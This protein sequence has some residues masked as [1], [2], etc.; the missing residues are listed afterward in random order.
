MKK[1]FLLV[2]TIMILAA[3]SQDKT[4]KYEYTFTGQSQY[5]TGDLIVKGSETFGKKA[6]KTTY[7]NNENTEFVLKYKGPI[8]EMEQVKTIKYSYKTNTGEGSGT[9]NISKI[10]PNDEI[11]I[12][13]KTASKG[14]AKIVKDEVV[15]V[16]V[17]W[18]ENEDSFTLKNKDANN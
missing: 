8:N 5:W 18:G 9:E 13:H 1:V 4:T 17:K 14:A 2:F 11:V 3:C 12:N 10:K 15:Q 16:N 6:D 7:S